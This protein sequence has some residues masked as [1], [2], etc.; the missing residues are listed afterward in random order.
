MCGD[1]VTQEI[2]KGEISS[3]NL[4]HISLLLNKTHVTAATMFRTQTIP[5]EATFLSGR[6]GPGGASAASCSA[7]LRPTET[8]ARPA[9]SLHR[10]S[11]SHHHTDQTE[12][13]PSD[14]TLTAREGKRE[15]RR[16][17]VTAATEPGGVRPEN[18]RIIQE[19]CMNLGPLWAPN[20]AEAADCVHAAGGTNS[21]VKFSAPSRRIWVKFDL[22][23]LLVPG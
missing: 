7:A 10:V 1:S 3:G 20:R 9:D 11:V 17:A 15:R 22:R 12:S 13:Q 21:K 14:P 8:T 6:T 4:Q 18:G 2:H 5:E 16:C 23:G 19:K